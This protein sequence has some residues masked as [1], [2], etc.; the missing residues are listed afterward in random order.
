M[1]LIYAPAIGEV[2]DG[3]RDAGSAPLGLARTMP[4]AAYRSP[5]LYELEVSELFRPGWIV[6]G[7]VSEVPEPGDYRCV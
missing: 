1:A 3:I 5:E 2:L 4:P 6:V 7:H